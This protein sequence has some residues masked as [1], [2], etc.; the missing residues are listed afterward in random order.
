MI[1]D[2][3][4]FEDSGSRH[5]GGTLTLLEGLLKSNQFKVQDGS[6]T[7]MLAI[8]KSSSSNAKLLNL[9][10]QLQASHD[11]CAVVYLDSKG[12][13]GILT[14]A[15]AADLEKVDP[16]LS[17]CFKCTVVEDQTSDQQ[18]SANF[19]NTLQ[20]KKEERHLKQTFHL[21]NLNNWVKTALIDFAC[22]LFV[23][24][25]NGVSVLDLGCGKGGDIMKWTKCKCGGLN[26][27]V[28]I[29][30]AKVSLQ[31]FV[32]YRMTPKVQS[33]IA[34]DMGDVDRSLSKS[35]SDVYVSATGTWEKRVPLP[36]SHPKFDIASCQFALHYMFQTKQRALHFMREVSTQLHP[37]SCFIA[38]TID[39][40]V[41]VD[42]ALKEASTNGYTDKSD[43][44]FRDLKIY[45]DKLESSEDAP[46][47]MLRLRFDNSM[48]Q[49]LVAIPQHENAP[50]RE[51]ATADT[52][53]FGL[54]YT[55]TLVES[56][57]GKGA[58][59]FVSAVDAPEWLVPLGS[60]L[61]NLASSCGM[62]VVLCQNFHQFI[63]QRAGNHILRD[64]L[65]N[66][67]VFNIDGSISEAEWK[68]AGLYAV[69]VFQKLEDR[70]TRIS[71]HRPSSPDGPPPRHRPTSPEGPPP[72]NRP[73]SPEGP[74]PRHRPT[75][76]EGPPPQFVPTS[77]E[78]PPP[79]TAPLE[80][81]PTSP[82]C[83]PPQFDPTSPECP[84]PQFVPTSPEG[85]PPQFVPTSPEGPPPQF[86]P[87]SPEGPPPRN[88]PTSPEGPPPQFVP[89]SPEG[90]P[91]QF[92]PTS[93]ECPPPQ[94]V[95][96][97]P[98]CPPPQFV[99]TSPEGPPPQFVPT[100]PE[101]PPPQFV[102][103]SPE[104]PPP[105]NLNRPI[106]SNSL[107]N[108]DDDSDSDDSIDEETR[109]L[110]RVRDKAVQLCVNN[111][112]IWDTVDENTRKSYMDQARQYLE[113]EDEPSAKRTRLT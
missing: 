34:T 3:Y 57:S 95:P 97:S 63:I 6:H 9:Y 60:E 2:V 70:S 54:R 10:S 76:P 23:G 66:M 93:P 65:R 75:S 81:V 67:N 14:S 69:I 37:G 71:Q 90:P 20:R 89:T 24:K 112:Q 107:Q 33:L 88:R 17:A 106:T 110:L 73:S 35:A 99:P 96:T 22:D 103:T 40:R 55:F 56:P 80:F 79:D 28:G 11:E 58:E 98:E 84:P 29:D 43:E 38:T 100:S 62:K 101:G 51:N 25:E 109:N 102:P 13:R 49:R 18:A 87:T 91:P 72:R 4:S 46:S 1:G 12:T 92:V 82:E 74:P 15:H 41:I 45:A 30:I 61:E 83:P 21:F 94:F 108:A 8:T 47:L 27:Y 113:D 111:G 104:G 52:D 31:D 50:F 64:L 5:L 42:W 78:G 39:S 19:Y 85:P 32:Q 16:K 105:P 59:N 86:V 44:S 48:W 68:I 36:P 77:P 53:P 7:F 26:L